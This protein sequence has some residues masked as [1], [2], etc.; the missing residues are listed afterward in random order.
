MLASS[1]WDIIDL[2]RKLLAMFQQLYFTSF[3]I[4]V[5]IHL[6]NKVIAN[7]KLLVMVILHL[8]KNKRRLG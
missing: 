7:I 5:T 6:H 2:I 4:A 8:D 3:N 1:F